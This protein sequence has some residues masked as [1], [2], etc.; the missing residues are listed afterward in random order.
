M[1]RICGTFFNEAFG[2]IVIGRYA[3][4]YGRRRALVVCNFL[5][6]LATVAMALVQVSLLGP[7]VVV[8][9]LL[10]QMV[11]ALVLVVNIQR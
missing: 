7:Y 6:G 3:D 8:V 5:T 9:F 1:G 4:K 2:G 11:Q 10:F